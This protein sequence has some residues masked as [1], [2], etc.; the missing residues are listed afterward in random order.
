[1]KIIL[2]ILFLSLLTLGSDLDKTLNLFQSGY[3]SEAV[4]LSESIPSEDPDRLSHDLLRGMSLYKMKDF[5]ETKR[6]L[7]LVSQEADDA[8]IK[9][10]ANY[11]YALASIKLGENIAGSV[12][13]TRLLNSSSPEISSGSKSILE[14][15][16]NY[17]FDD[18]D[19]K[20]ILEEIYDMEAL[21]YIEQ[22]RNSLKIL[23]VLPTTG[24][25]Q[26]EGRDILTGLEFGL[27]KLQPKINNIR[28]DVVN[29][30][31]KIPVMTKKV[32]EK[33]NSTR[34]NLIVGELR[35]DAT[36]A[37]AGIAELKN[38]PLISPTAT[39][40]GI[41]EISERVFQLNTTSYTLGSLIAEYAVDSLGYKTFAVIS[42]L[43]EDGNESVE[44]FTS[45]ILEKGCSVIALEWYFDSYDINKQIQ[46]IREK[47]LSI[48]SLDTE[49]YMST[50]SIKA[51][52][53]GIVDAFFLPLPDS[54]TESVMSQLSYYNFKA[55]SIGTYGW[56]NEKILNKLNIHADSL[57][58]IKESSYNIDNPD[59]TDFVY[60]FRNDFN[61]NPRLLEILG[62]S[63]MDMLVDLKSRHKDTSVNRILLE[64]EYYEGIY[65]DIIYN[66]SRS[67]S[68]AD[69]F[70]FRE[71]SGLKKIDF[72]PK[73]SIDS[74]SNA[75]IFYNRG[76]V[77]EATK[78]FGSAVL[79]YERSIAEYRKA[80]PGSDFKDHPDVISLYRK[81]G[82][83]HYFLR[84][85]SNAEAYFRKYLES[86]RWD[87]REI[88]FRNKVSEANID[89][90]ISPDVLSEYTNDPELAPEA[91]FEIGNL[92]LKRSEIKKALDYLE[93]SAA[94]K[95]KDAV[96][97]LNEMKNID[98][99]KNDNK[100]DW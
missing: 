89:P 53:A 31:G 18:A 80:L 39:A 84:D 65:G 98:D 34:Y 69:L 15:L 83:V 24:I 8:R 48:D 68:A 37:L 6:I 9:D 67:N 93:A 92:Y 35:S 55:K 76:C 29:S 79:N 74:L 64:T 52:P 75:K 71:R 13:L 85:F 47:V 33:L 41:S 70:M 72:V 63:I 78:Q 20:E 88:S 56:N 54:D 36:A 14:N 99:N 22:S 81:T 95:N 10:L 21:R 43:T 38:I 59:Y 16:I 25:D 94:L 3:Y 46:R 44:G 87:D 96:K 1:M 73:Y 91:Y 57:V 90:L 45:K 77:D 49:E 82:T 62:Y 23:A 40:R 86:G 97:I 28:L 2:P 27:K 12:I 58:F 42:P 7:D 66:S 26:D 11:Y 50:D 32:I 19:Y 60:K 30:E 100:F 61:R 5:R 51:V 17:K 4:K